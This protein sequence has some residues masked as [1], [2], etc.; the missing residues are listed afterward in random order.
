[1]GLDISVFMAV[2]VKGDYGLIQVHGVLNDHH[3]D[4]EE[5]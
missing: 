3:Q 2:G 1:M 4:V 5:W